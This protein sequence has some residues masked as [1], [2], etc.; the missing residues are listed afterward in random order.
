MRNRVV[1]VAKLSNPTGG[2]SSA[3][4][5]TVVFDY[6]DV[7]PQDLDKFYSGSYKV[8]L[9]GPAAATFMAK[10]AKADVQLTFT[11]GAFAP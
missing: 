9:A 4:D 10:G 7:T 3:L 5:M 1:P 8:V 6:A 2:K 11:F